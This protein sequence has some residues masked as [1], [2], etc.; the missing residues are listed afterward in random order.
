MI[1]IVTGAASGI[2]KGLAAALAAR[3]ADLVLADLNLEALEGHAATLGWPPGRTVLRRV[4]VRDPAA[5]RAVVDAAVRRFGGLDVLFN[6]AGYLKA[7]V[8]HESSPEEIDR[9]IDVN[10]KGVIHGT[11]AA[12]A[13]MVPRRA[14]H[15]VNMGSLA[16]LAAVP[17]LAL[18]TASKFAVRGFSLAAAAELRPH[19]V[20]VTLVC[21]DAVRTP[22]LDKQLDDR[23]AALTFSGPRPL[24]VDEVVRTILGPVLERRPLEIAFPRSRGWLA[25]LSGFLPD[26]ALAIRPMLERKGIAGQDAERARRAG[27]G[28]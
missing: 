8:A 14:G 17:G 20:A 4:A 19:G 23:H 13:V 10:C 26:V 24:D 28:A 6:I 11:R 9:H 12:A 2:G 21:P 16:A 25:R 22:M 3:G 1:A 7:G 27:P 18:Y 15:I 5:W